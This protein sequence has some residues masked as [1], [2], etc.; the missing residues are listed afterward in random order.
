MKLYLFKSI[1]F[2]NLEITSVIKEVSL[3]VKLSLIFSFA[4]WALESENP[5]PVSKN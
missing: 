4:L 1:I 2:H 3:A 5:T